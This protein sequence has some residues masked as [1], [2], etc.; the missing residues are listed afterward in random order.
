MP[1]RFANILLAISMSISII[2]LIANASVLGTDWDDMSNAS[3]CRDIRTW[4]LLQVIISSLCTTCYLIIWIASSIKEIPEIINRIICIS[5]IIL[6]ILVI[7]FNCSMYVWGWVLWSTHT[8]DTVSSTYNMILA[9]LIIYTIMYSIILISS[10]V[11]E[12]ITLLK[13]LFGDE[14]MAETLL[15][16]GAF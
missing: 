15:P 6:V 2:I 10:A 12:T 16:H 8:C 9:D 3:I 1:S 7:S 14:P 11:K 4:L 13:D 5:T